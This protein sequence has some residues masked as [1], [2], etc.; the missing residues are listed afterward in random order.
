MLLLLTCG[1]FSLQAQ[2]SSQRIDYKTP[3]RYKDLTDP[4]PAVTEKKDVTCYPSVGMRRAFDRKD[5][6]YM[7]FNFQSI[8]KEAGDK[9]RQVMPDFDENANYLGNEE[10][11]RQREAG[12][13]PWIDGKIVRKMNADSAFCFSVPSADFEPYE[14]KYENRLVVVIHKKDRADI[15]IEYFYHSKRERRVRRQIGRLDA[16]LKFL[17]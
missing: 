17:L 13:K 3:R 2:D 14:G 16:V 1:F 9:V 11:K 10:C 12:W 8:S 5:D 7:R 15:T 6:I 4:G